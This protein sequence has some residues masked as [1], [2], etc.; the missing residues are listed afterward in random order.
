MAVTESSLSALRILIAVEEI[1][2]VDG[3]RI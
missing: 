2:D 3:A 1:W